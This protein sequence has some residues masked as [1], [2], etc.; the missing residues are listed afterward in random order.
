VAIPTSE[1][2]SHDDLFVRIRFQEFK[3]G[4]HCTSV[5]FESQADGPAVSPGAI[6]DIDM[7]DL[8]DQAISYQAVGARSSIQMYGPDGPIADPAGR[9]N[10]P[11]DRM[12]SRSQMDSTASDA[13]AVHRIRSVDDDL[14][15]EVAAVYLADDTGRPTEAVK[16]KLN[17]SKRNATRWVALARGRGF[18]PPYERSRKS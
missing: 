16:E 8:I 14:L 2:E 18:I 15:R 11:I 4:I 9:I 6:R 17:T 1:G 10:I 12:M 3:D 5:A 7:A 13:V